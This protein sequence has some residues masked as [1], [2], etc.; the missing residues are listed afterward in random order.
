LAEYQREEDHEFSDEAGVSILE[1]VDA[2]LVSLLQPVTYEA[3][4][5]RTIC[6]RLAQI[7]R[8]KALSVVAISSPTAGDGKTTTAINLAGT[9]AQYPETSVLLIDMDLRRPV[10]SQRL[11]IRERGKPGFVEMIRQP[12]LSLQDAVQRLPVANLSFLP[13]GASTALPHDILN[14]HRVGEL[15]R[16]ARQNYD[17]VVLDLPPLVPFLD[18]RSLETWID[19]L[20]LIVAAHKT[21]RK[22]TEEAI[23]AVDPAK[24]VG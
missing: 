2:H 4:Q 6:H 13:T 20:V 14:S 23:Q 16:E 22:L 8:E 15:L 21:L 17:Y 24:L 7:R 19:G 9:L 5:Y 11:G 12:M 3:E 18:A 1:D 10:I